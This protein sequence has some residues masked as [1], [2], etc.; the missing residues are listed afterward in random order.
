MTD[1]SHQIPKWRE[2]LTV[3]AQIACIIA[4]AAALTGTTIAM[5]NFFFH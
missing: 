5:I 1:V 3:A 4:C 2:R